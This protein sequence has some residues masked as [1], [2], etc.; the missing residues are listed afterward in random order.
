LRT[1]RTWLLL[2]LVVLLPIRAAVA[3]AMLCPPASSGSQ[4][5]LQL[6]HQGAHGHNGADAAMDHAGHEPVSTAQ[7]D[8]SSGGTDHHFAGQPD[9]CNLC[10]AFCSVTPLVS[11]LTINFLVEDLTEASF[12][13]VPTWLPS[14]IPAGQERP[15]RSI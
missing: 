6:K 10:S 11:T 4:T 8:S 15:P 14:F 12:P 13:D 3:A 2:L 5:E 1:F 7:H 9:K